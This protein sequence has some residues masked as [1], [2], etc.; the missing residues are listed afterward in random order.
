MRV[1]AAD[2][3]AP[4]PAAPVP[5]GY[6][7]RPASRS[8]MDVLAELY[9]HAYDAG[10]AVGTLDAAR[11]DLWATFDGRYGDLWPD[12]S[13]VAVHH[14]TV[15]AAVLTVH[16]ATWE[17][18]PDHPYIIEAMTAHGYRRRGLA[19]TLLTVVCATLAQAGE[20]TVALTVDEANTN[21]VALYESLGFQ[22][23]ITPT[24]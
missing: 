7:I 20:H 3:S 12:A 23:V 14:H 2:L 11:E 19:R 16:E 24:R 10:V 5:P 15:V 17:D 1:Y 18:A 21:A 8:D 13:P 22:R 6:Q 9:L 4:R